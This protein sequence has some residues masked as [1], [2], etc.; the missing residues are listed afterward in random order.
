MTLRHRIRFYQQLAVLARAGVPLRGSLERLEKNHASPEVRTLIAQLAQ[1]QTLGE[2]FTAAR[3]SPFECHL[4]AAG[5]RSAQLDSIFELLGEFWNRELR[6]VQAVVRQLYYPALVV[7]L[8][9][10]VLGLLHLVKG[11]GMPAVITSIVENL[12]LL[13]VISFALY[14]VIS[15]SWRSA[16]AQRFWLLVPIIGG[17]L[18]AANAYRWITVLRMEFVAG[19]SFPD[20][21]A[22]AWRSSGY[23]HSEGRALEAERDMRSGIDLSQLVRGWRQLPRDWI[24]YF[25]TAEASGQY[26][27]TFKQI[28]VEAVHGWTVTQDRMAEWIPKILY[29]VFLIVMAFELVSMGSQ[30]VLGPE[31]EVQKAIDG[32]GP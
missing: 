17:A 32:T 28:E 25:D 5:E 19:V 18:R 29:F 16:V 21:V 27:T 30:V 31:E 13:Y 3:F 7:H 6:F 4:V 26:E 22:D 10:V 2:A 12:F 1:G 20:A 11:Q 14:L 9:I 24:D 15:I 23:V 8:A